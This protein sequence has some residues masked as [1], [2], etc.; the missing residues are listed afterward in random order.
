VITGTQLVALCL[1]AVGG[2]IWWLRPGMKQV[3]VPATR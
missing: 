1:I 2:L 3:P